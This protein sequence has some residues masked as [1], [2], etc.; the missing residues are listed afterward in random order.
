MEPP[1]TA[2]VSNCIS[3]DSAYRE[4]ID[5]RKTPGGLSTVERRSH[6][7]RM[8]SVVVSDCSEEPADSHDDFTRKEQSILSSSTLLMRK[9]TTHDEFGAGAGRAWSSWPAGPGTTCSN[10]SSAA[11]RASP[12][13]DEL[14]INNLLSVRRLSDCSSSS[15]LATLDMEPYCSAHAGQAI[16]D[17]FDAQNETLID[18]GFSSSED[19]AAHDD[20]DSVASPETDR[21][22][23]TVNNKVRIT[24]LTG[25]RQQSFEFK[26]I[27]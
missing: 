27:A 20:K 2:C 9:L 8:P 19:V 25:Q 26:F 12:P 23:K 18:A 17:A 5:D 21:R 22:H 7:M 4:V 3:W 14:V 11:G 10:S 24:L 6:T 15:S 16:S 1:A 13:G